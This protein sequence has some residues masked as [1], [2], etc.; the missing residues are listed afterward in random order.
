MDHGDGKKAGAL[1][2]SHANHLV[3]Y[4]RKEIAKRGKLGKPVVTRT[5]ITGHVVKRVSIPFR[6]PRIET[7]IGADRATVL[8]SADGVSR[9]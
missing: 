2:A 8:E 7:S 3:K 6:A 4:L 1:L 9:R 5:G